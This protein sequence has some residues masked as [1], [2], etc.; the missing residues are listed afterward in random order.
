[1]II[2]ETEQLH[3]QL[4]H[5]AAE[6]MVPSAPHPEPFEQ[7]E[8]FVRSSRLELDFLRGE[9]EKVRERASRVPTTEEGFIT[10]YQELLASGPGQHHLLFNWL[11]T[12]AT[13]DEMRW[14]IQQ[15]VAG[16]AGFEDLLALTQLRMPEVVKLEMARNF[17]DEM[18]RGRAQGMHGPMLANIAKALNVA[19]L[20]SSQLVWPSLALA[21][22]M[23]G[24][25]L[26]RS[27]AYH[28]IGALGVIELTAPSRA[29][30]VADGLDRLGLPRANCHYYRLHAT[31]DILH[32]QQWQTGVL[33]PLIRQDPSL[34]THLA[35]GA[36]MRLEAG[37]RCFTSYST[38]FGLNS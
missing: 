29:K 7:I 17:W 33:R 4:L 3:C 37:A 21:N 24:F 1:M 30:L 20:P 23:S 12:E 19:A 15:E 6:R 28:S 5:F 38:H 18:G 8:R 32:N 35:E 36:L 22:L 31:V 11:A 2:E 26:N 10:W 27:Y 34:V 13:L 16:E 25:A 14:F 9:R